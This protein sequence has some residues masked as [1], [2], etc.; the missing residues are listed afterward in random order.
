MKK[1]F[2][3]LAVFSSALFL[4]SASSEKNCFSESVTC[5]IK[6]LVQAECNQ[7][8]QA[9]QA[10][11]QEHY[12]RPLFVGIEYDHLPESSL[13]RLRLQKR[14]EI[15]SSIPHELNRSLYENVCNINNHHNEL[16]TKICFCDRCQIVA[17]EDA[18][19]LIE[20]RSEFYAAF[21]KAVLGSDETSPYLILN[22]RAVLPENSIWIDIIDHAIEMEK[23][24]EIEK[25][26][27]SMFRKVCYY[28][29]CRPSV[30][31]HD[32]FEDDQE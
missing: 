26:P 17:I 19:S 14:N 5:S 29:S 22:M 31:F 2:L 8:A 3:F 32:P 11:A 24:K 28:S 27:E 1:L 16:R 21:E 7:L 15:A 23:Q 4:K 30:K 25:A 12:S 18:F 13:L 6:D 20:T 10:A 9:M